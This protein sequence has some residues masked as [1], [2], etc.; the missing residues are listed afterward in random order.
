MS[1]ATAKTWRLPPFLVFPRS[2]VRTD[3]RICPRSR[4]VYGEFCDLPTWPC[5]RGSQSAL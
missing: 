1:L 4:P 2:S 5:R 3:W